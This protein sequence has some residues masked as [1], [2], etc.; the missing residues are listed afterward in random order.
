MKQNQRHHGI[1]LTFNHT[2]LSSP[3]NLPEATLP[4]A[5]LGQQAWLAMA[6]KGVSRVWGCAK[7]LRMTCSIWLHHD[8][9]IQ[10]L[11]AEP[12]AV[13]HFDDQSLICHE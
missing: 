11:G 13:T 12:S 6:S 7:P 2:H 10:A 9:C 5:V 4:H 3:Y 1:H 8:T